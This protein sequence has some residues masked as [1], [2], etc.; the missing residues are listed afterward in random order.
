MFFSVFCIKQN[1]LVNYCT[2][3]I[4]VDDPFSMNLFTYTTKT[5]KINAN[6]INI[7]INII[8]IIIIVLIKRITANVC[9][10]LLLKYY[11]TID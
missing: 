10:T 2:N 4:V 5:Y 6:I 9:K 1:K 8:N 11:K 3:H 7:I